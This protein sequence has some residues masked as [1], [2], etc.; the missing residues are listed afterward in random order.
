MTLYIDKNPF[1]DNPTTGG[2]FPTLEDCGVCDDARAIEPIPLTYD[3]PC[4]WFWDYEDTCEG[5]TISFQAIVELT[6][7]TPGVVN[8]S[9][10]LSTSTVGPGPGLELGQHTVGWNGT[11]DSDECDNWSLTFNTPPG[12]NSYSTPDHH[13]ACYIDWPA[14]LPI[15]IG[16]SP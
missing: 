4:I 16:T 3:S 7:E 10:Q 5:Y 9:I 12:L 1:A 6:C 2:G 15:T 13:P 14:I 8:V 11:I